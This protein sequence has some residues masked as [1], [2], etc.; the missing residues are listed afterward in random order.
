MSSLE[1]RALRK[2]V[3]IVEAEVANRVEN[4]T[5]KITDL[6]NRLRNFETNVLIDDQNKLTI[7]LTDEKW[8]VNNWGSFINKFKTEL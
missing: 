3:K 1:K 4:L 6:E 7:D 2:V 8:N 5:N